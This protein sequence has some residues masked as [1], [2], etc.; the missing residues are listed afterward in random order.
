MGRSRVLRIRMDLSMLDQLQELADAWHQ[1]VSV[2]ARD[3]IADL[4]RHPERYVELFAARRPD[5]FEDERLP[6]QA[7]AWEQDRERLVHVD[8]GPLLAS[9]AAR[10]TGA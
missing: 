8:M 3:A 4:L 6:Q 1:P 10:G 2:V 9:M 5:A 7:Q